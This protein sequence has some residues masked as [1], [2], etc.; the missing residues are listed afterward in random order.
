MEQKEKIWANGLTVDQTIEEFNR[1]YRMITQKHLKRYH[2][3]HK[4][5]VIYM[6]KD[7]KITEDDLLN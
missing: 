6:L 4:V 7:G 2:C 3:K 1:I 5:N